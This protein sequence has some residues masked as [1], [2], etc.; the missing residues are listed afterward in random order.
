MLFDL[1]IRKDHE[2]LTPVTQDLVSKMTIRA[3]H[4]VADILGDSAA[5]ID[6]IIWSHHHFDHIGNPATF[7]P[8][9][10]LIVGENFKKEFLP[11]YPEREDSWIRQSDYEGRELREVSFSEPGGLKIGQY[12]AIDFL[13]DGSF[14][15]L[16]C[17]GHTIG[18]LMG[19]ART[20]PTTFVLFAADCCHHG[21]EIRPSEFK[22]LPDEITPNPLIN[23]PRYP[24][25]RPCPA[26]LFTAIHPHRSRTKPFYELVNP[27]DLD[28]VREATRSQRKLEDFDANDDILVLS[29]HDA[30]AAEV[31]DLYPKDINNWKEK[32]WKA[33]LHWAFLNDFEVA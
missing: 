5:E 2:N 10:H 21:G 25:S 18:H 20:T 26:S 7:P 32:G 17:P 30:N 9:T 8:T 1:G 31:V 24:R 16:D 33:Q 6:D 23:H 27:R 4:D 12:N 3:T 22:P 14:Y 19:L 13:G 11:G 29:A 15:L 28:S